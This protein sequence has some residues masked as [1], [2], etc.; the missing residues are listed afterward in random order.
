MPSERWIHDSSLQVLGV[1]VGR[2]GG[3]TL[4]DVIQDEITGPLGMMDTGYTVSTTDCHLFHP[5]PAA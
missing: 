3:D 2:A 5:C 1:L 4:G